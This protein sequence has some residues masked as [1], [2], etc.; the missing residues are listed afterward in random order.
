[1]RVVCQKDEA[2][3]KLT[4]QDERIKEL[5]AEQD[6]SRQEVARLEACVRREALL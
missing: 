3:Q 6:V 1:M 4:E 2:W 5:E